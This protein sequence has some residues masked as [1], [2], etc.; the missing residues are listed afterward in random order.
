MPLNVTLEISD[1]ELEQFR[2]VLAGARER[3]AGKTAREVAAAARAAVDKLRAGTPSP[4]VAARLRKVHALA[5]MLEDPEWQLPEPERRRVLDGL[6]YVAD[7]HDLVP[8]NVPVLGLV[9]D[10]I[11]LEL[12]LRELQHELDGYND[13]HEFRQHELARPGT[14]A[15]PSAS[16]EE[17]LDSKRRS[18]HD[19]I[20]DR[21]QRELEQRGGDFPLITHF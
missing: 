1:R 17:W 3:T 6:A 11:M 2:A 8:D 4:F 21:R 19:R 9:D 10:A 12:V 18:L 14:S 20:R 13:F 16:R 5:D 15:H 7:V